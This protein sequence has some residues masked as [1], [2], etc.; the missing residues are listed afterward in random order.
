MD[1][2]IVRSTTANSVLWRRRI[3]YIHGIKHILKC[4][5]CANP[6]H[7]RKKIDIKHL[8]N[9][10]YCCELLSSGSHNTIKP[11]HKEAS[12]TEM[13]FIRCKLY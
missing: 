2:W 5:K 8:D 3:S 6:S 4:I 9:E 1:P 11:S 13:L 12:I 7:V 10:C